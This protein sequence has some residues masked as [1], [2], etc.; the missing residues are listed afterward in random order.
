M[1][2]YL[3]DFGRLDL[4]FLGEVHVALPTY[5]PL[6]ATALVVS[7]LWFFR[8]VRRDGLPVE[9]AA[10][11]AFWTLVSGLVGGKLGLVI[12]DLDWYLANPGR[13][14]SVD[15]LTAA[16]VIWAALLCGL[17]GLIVSARMNGL[18]AGL[19][20]D[21]AAVTLPVAQ[22]IG[23]VGCLMAGCCY[24][25]ACAPPGDECT[26]PWAVVYHSHEAH[27]RTGVPFGVELHPT[28]VYEILWSLAVV[29]PVVLL[30]RRMRAAPGE[31]ILAYFATYGTGRFVIE[32]FRGD[33]ARGLWFKDLSAG[34]PDDLLSTS[35]IVSLAVVP[36]AVL[37]WVR[38]RRSASGDEERR[39]A[40][41]P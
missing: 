35:Q 32:F 3:I 22:S 16:G 7:W 9:P 18:P 30:V 17:A 12:V 29:L 20:L 1:H 23:R 39:P 40:V 25:R 2:P 10:R 26:L 13:L 21:A 14:L 41:R 19:V 5:G 33:P 38:L 15:L 8:I 36:L 37:L 31:V 11:V 28:P 24:G 34:S 27:L 6:V 4:P